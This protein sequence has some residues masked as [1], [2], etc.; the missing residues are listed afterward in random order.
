MTKLIYAH[1]GKKEKK[2]KIPEHVE[3][4]KERRETIHKA[5]TVVDIPEHFLAGFLL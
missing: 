5:L 2:K 4:W 1:G 3:T